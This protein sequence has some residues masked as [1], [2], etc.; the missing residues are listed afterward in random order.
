MKKSLNQLLSLVLSVCMVFSLFTAAPLGATAAQPKR[1]NLA[2]NKPVEASGHEVS[3]GRFLK[4][5]AVD[6][7]ASTNA[8]RWS[9]NKSLPDEPVWIYV[10]LGEIKSFEEI[11]LT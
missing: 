7:D 3:D 4:E 8:K 9:S 11:V 6:G 2:L 1:T 5:F 10:D